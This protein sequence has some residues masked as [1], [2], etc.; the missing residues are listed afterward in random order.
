[1]FNWSNIHFEDGM[2]V[3]GNYGG[4]SYSAGEVGGTATN[5]PSVEPVDDF[6]TLF[7][8]HDLVYQDET[9]TTADLREADVQLIGGLYQELSDW[10][11]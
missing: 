8:Q 4:L 11:L 5:P 7:W 10:L 2:L 6:D 1:M 3:Y 9:S